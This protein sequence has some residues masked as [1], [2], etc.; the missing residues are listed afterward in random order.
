MQM[1]KEAI[2]LSVFVSVLLTI[3]FFG[4][5]IKSLPDILRKGEIAYEVCREDIL[6][7]NKDNDYEFGDIKVYKNIILGESYKND[8]YPQCF[9]SKT[10]HLYYKNDISLGS[11]GD[12]DVIYADASLGNGLI[13][14]IN[15]KTILADKD[16]E[17]F[18]NMFILFKNRKFK[19]CAIRIKQNDKH[20]VVFDLVVFEETSISKASAFMTKALKNYRYGSK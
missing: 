1:K 12:V 13:R 8:E 17:S 6:K 15:L 4:D 16:A 7:A 5:Y 18:E 20:C 9:S 19:N 11:V 2:C 3:Y 14:S 10:G